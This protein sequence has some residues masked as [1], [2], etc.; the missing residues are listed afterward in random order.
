M[1]LTSSI[2]QYNIPHEPIKAVD[3]QHREAAFIMLRQSRNGRAMP[4]GGQ[5][6]HMKSTNSW[7]AQANI[8]DSL[9]TAGKTLS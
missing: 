2:P 9:Y 4:E 7:K 1:L 3:M 8:D 6:V 5:R